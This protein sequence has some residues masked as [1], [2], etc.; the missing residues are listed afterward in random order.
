MQRKWMSRIENRLVK[1]KGEVDDDVFF[2]A[3]VVDSVMEGEKARIRRINPPPRE[4]I[5]YVGVEELELCC[6]DDYEIGDGFSRLV[7]QSLNRKIDFN[8]VSMRAGTTTFRPFQFRPLLSYMEN[9]RRRI[10]IADE[11]GLGKTISAIY[12]M[13][14]EMARF[15]MERVVIICPSHLRLKWRRELW[16]R[17]GLYFEVV[18]GRRFLDAISGSDRFRYIVSMDAMAG[19]LVSFREK[20]GHCPQIDMLIVDEVH[21]LIGRGIDTQ[22]REFVQSLSMISDRV[23]GLTATPIQLELMD[24]KRILDVID[25][26]EWDDKQFFNVMNLQSKLNQIYR[27]LS[28]KDLGDDDWDEIRD[29]VAKAFSQSILLGDEHLI[30]KMEQ[31][32]KSLNKD[33]VSNT[34]EFLTLRRKIRDASP[35]AKR[36]TRARRIE[37]GEDRQ[38]EPITIRIK[39]DNTV[40]TAIQRGKEI[41]VSEHSLFSEVDAF[42]N[43]SFSHVHR[44]QLSSCLPAMIG[45]LESGMKGFRVWTNG[46]RIISDYERFHLDTEGKEG[47]KTCTQSLTEDEIARCKELADQYHLLRTDTKF[48]RMMEELRRLASEGKAR[49]AIVFTQWKP[50]IEHLRVKSS[51]INDIKCFL[52][53]GDDSPEKRE[54]TMSNFKG[55]DGFTILFTADVLSEGLDL[56]SADCVVNY[57]LPYNPQRVEQRIGRV[58]RI[59]QT[60]D[61]ITVINI[62]VEGSTDEEIYN[63]L[64]SRIGVFKRY[65]G[66]VPPTLEL[67][68][69]IG[70]VVDQDEIV[71]E[72]ERL[73]DLERLQNHYALEGLDDI[74]DEETVEI[75]N[76]KRKDPSQQRLIVLRDLFQIIFGKEA[77]DASSSSSSLLVLKHLIPEDAEIVAQIV[78][79]ECADDIRRKLRFYIDSKSNLILSTEPGNSDWY[80]PLMHPLMR[81]AI[82]IVYSQHY[83]DPDKIP[84]E[85][86]ETTNDIEDVAGHCSGLIISEHIFKSRWSKETYWK[87]WK[88]DNS[89]DKTELLDE[90][91]IRTLAESATKW[92]YRS[93]S[94]DKGLSMLSNQVRSTI[95]EE[96]VKWLMKLKRNTKSQILTA[97]EAETE[98][99]RIRKWRIERILNASDI[100]ESVLVNLKQELK[101]LEMANQDLMGEITKIQEGST[102]FLCKEEGWR[103]VAIFIG[104]KMLERL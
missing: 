36:L 72:I 102:D 96:H 12:I 40:V 81:T 95:D 39:L 2:V 16:H 97:K 33:F 88:V 61:H 78:P 50:T 43:A 100:E 29:L 65:I 26:R 42:L 34:E 30:K 38:R 11:V 57:D 31:L 3:S 32:S 48:N 64:M 44:R 62:L 80:I 68:T 85:I 99:L 98:R 94:H 10:L 45:L 58:D 23:I 53:S 76:A 37:V 93:A 83:P 82:R 101:R 20:R 73:E 28:L 35:L 89:L 15:S 17:F 103:L 1:R 60:S 22:R 54:R 69:T 63:K 59:G 6:R 104:G 52:I 27:V 70:G 67:T 84:V 47:W 75:Y 74:L 71:K 14:E 25:P 79:I 41:S 86:I 77:I 8:G 90:I 51:S 91:D 5:G 18:S 19:K 87:W 24:L 21:H 49:K 66:D 4:D 13:V 56:Y 9:P 55:Y 46:R 7:V 92:R